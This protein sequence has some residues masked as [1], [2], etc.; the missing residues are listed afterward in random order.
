MSGAPHDQQARAAASPRPTMDT[1]RLP[2]AIGNL[3]ALQT[4][5][6]G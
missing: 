1:T 5:N 2:E 4:L 6:L 3:T